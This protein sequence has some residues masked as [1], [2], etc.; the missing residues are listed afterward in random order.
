MWFT[1][2]GEYVNQSWKE[3]SLIAL[4][5]SVIPFVGWV[6]IVIMALITLRKG[7]KQGLI[8]LFVTAIP[9][10]ILLYMGMNVPWVIIMLC[11]NVFTWVLA[12]VLRSQA[13]WGKVLSACVIATIIAAVA[14]NLIVP[15]LQGFWYNALHKAYTQANQEMALFLKAPP[16]NVNL[17]TY[18]REV[19]R[20]ITPVIILFQVIASIINLGLARWW[21]SSLFNPGGFAKEISETRLSYSA[22]V[23]TMMTAA[24]IFLGVKAG[25]DVLPTLIVVFFC[26]GVIVF[27]SIV[28]HK[29]SK[30]AW[31]WLF[32]GLM[33]LLFPYS[34]VIVAGLGI[35]DTFVDFRARQRT[36]TKSG[37]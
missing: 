1:R 19:S 13:S 10:L 9:G 21:Q 29:K 20:M 7:P 37:E 24:A 22:T 4:I 18:I 6:G 36:V 33:V 5:F 12:I 16:P 32:Y 35:T 2:F 31:L 34:F 23:L 28:R 26:V 8:L 15:D 11:G 25:W 3:A 27:H 14:L 30:S 17:E